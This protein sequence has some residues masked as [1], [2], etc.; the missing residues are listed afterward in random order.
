M[1]WQIKRNRTVI[2]ASRARARC[3]LRS[4]RYYRKI[5]NSWAAADALTQFRAEFERYR[6]FLRVLTV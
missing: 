5:G 6:L 2:A 3:C 4:A 1:D